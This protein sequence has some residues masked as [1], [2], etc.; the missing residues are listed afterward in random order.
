[1][2]NIKTL[3]DYF[4]EY[5][6]TLI[7]TATERTKPLHIPGVHEEADTSTLLRQPKRGQLPAITA[8]VRSLEE[9]KCVQ[10]ACATGT[11]KSYLSAAT[12]HAHAKG[13]PYRAIITCPPHLVDKWEREIHDTIPGVTTMVID[14]YS[15]LLKLR[16]GRKP[17]RVVYWIMSNTMAK[18]GA[19]W[20][21]C[22]NVYSKHL[23]GKGTRGGIVIRV[24]GVAYCP[25]CA[26]PQVKVDAT[27]G[28]TEFLEPELFHKRQ[29]SCCECGEPMWQNTGPLDR[30][31]I[32]RY[33][34]K[35]LK[36]FFDYGVFDESHKAKGDSTEIGSA[37]SWLAA[38]CKNT[39]AL[40]GTLLGG[41]AWHA[42]A[43]LYRMRP[44][45]LVAEGVEY[46]DLASFNER[47]G[48]FEF[49]VVEKEK[50]GVGH[51]YGKSTAKTKTV[52]NLKPGI[53]P[54]LFGR[55]LM[56]FC[57][58]LTLEDIA[59]DL[60]PS[61]EVLVPCDMD[62]ELAAEYRRIEEAIKKVLRQA[63]QSGDRSLLSNMLHTLLGYPD[64]SI[65]WET[66]MA[67]LKDE[68]GDP[69]EVAVVTPQELSQSVTRKKESELI[70][71]ILE[72]KKR[73]RKCWVYTTMVDKR[74]VLKR[75]T[76]ILRDQGLSVSVLRSSVDPRKREKWI[77]ENGPSSDVC[78]CHP[79]LVETGLDFFDKQ[80]TYNFPS[81]MFY[82]TGYEP[83]VM[84][85]AG[86][87][88][89]RIGQWAKC[90][91]LYFYYKGT[92][93]ERAMSLMAKKIAASKSIEGKFDTDGL[94]SLAGDYGTMELELAKS[95]IE[96]LTPPSVVGMGTATTDTDWL[97]GLVTA[98]PKIVVPETTT[99]AQPARSLRIEP[100]QWFRP[101]K[102]GQR[103]I[104]IR[105]VD[106]KFADF[107]EHGRKFMV[108]LRIEDILSR[109]VPCSEPVLSAPGQ[110][111]LF[112]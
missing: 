110:K 7:R 50:L 111:N 4:R 100:G 57:V 65:G 95:L 10:M 88:A 76:T 102:E 39:I 108:T 46:E 38:S 66:I 15:Q 43:M 70:H 106:G 71:A 14:H 32:A 81:L 40:T 80:R 87:R 59:T 1:M 69:Y 84:R 105:A 52:K 104:R 35:H 29:C 42:R 2:D 49:K 9:N 36:G 93:Q 28:Q 5:G 107:V 45:S 19:A 85:Q 51:K 58:F 30:W 91:T 41:Y 54:Q 6:D 12:C 90:E 109:Y 75:L 27:T 16:R 82:Q 94:V 103:H 44:V 55:H 47:Y 112:E 92:M 53:M 21:P 17:Q 73:G 79:S 20:K 34:H 68:C 56:P 25:S 67:K 48:R 18:L 26:A 63:L 60:P 101:R 37:F 22:L 74:D 3:A 78:M 98:K 61:R 11:G 13:K 72:R 96:Q 24:A 83:F 8:S 23:K 33:I 99:D 77:A 31:P 64:L 89:Y 86:G 62:P 97:G